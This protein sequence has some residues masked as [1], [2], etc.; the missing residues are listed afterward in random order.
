M[1]DVAY[2]MESEEESIRLE[3]KTDPAV[4]EQQ[5]LWAQI[6]PGMR[7]ADLGCGCGKTT[8][9]LHGLVQPGGT[10]VGVDVSE[11][12]LRYAKDNY[13][14]EGIE[15]V[16]ED[17]WRPLDALGSFDFVWLRFVLEYFRSN[18]FDIVANASRILK[19]GGTLCLIDLDHNCLSHFGLSE[20]LERAISKCAHVLEEEFNFDPYAGRKLYSYLYDLGYENVAVHVSAHHLIYGALGNVDAFNWTK[21]IEI[22][23]EK[24][25]LAFAEYTGGRDEFMEEFTRFFSNPRRFSYTPLIC[26]RGCKPA[27]TLITQT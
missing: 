15:F 6:R 12:R 25:G 9:V 22:V 21:K 1:E 5:A 11:K 3:A 17:I 27:Q 18:G 16:R 20:R 26:V 10:A 2:L 23:S 19:P 7:V 24:A 13:S 8:Y 4:V 14:R